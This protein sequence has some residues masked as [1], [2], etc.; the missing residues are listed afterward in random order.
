LQRP[1]SIE[2]LMLGRPGS[3]SGIN[4]AN[5]VNHGSA[6]QSFEIDWGE[7]SFFNHGLLV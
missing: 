5:A 1:A 6:H 4:P 2:F 3:Q 7:S